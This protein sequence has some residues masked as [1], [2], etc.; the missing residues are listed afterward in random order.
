MVRSNASCAVAA[1][2]SVIGHMKSEG[3][4]GRNYLKGRL[5]DRINPVLTATDNNLGLVFRWLRIP[6]QQI[7]TTL[8]RALAPQSAVKTAC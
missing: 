7:L 1:V 4:F 3:H 6:L 8:I 2:E 5:G